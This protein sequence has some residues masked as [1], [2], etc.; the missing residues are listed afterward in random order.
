MSASLS[1]MGSNGR[2][3]GSQQRE[4]KCLWRLGNVVNIVPLV[5]VIC[6]DW[7]SGEIRRTG[8]QGSDCEEAIMPPGH[9]ESES[10]S[11]GEEVLIHFHAGKKQLKVQGWLLT[12]QLPQICV[13]F[14]RAEGWCRNIKDWQGLSSQAARKSAEWKPLGPD[15]GINSFAQIPS[16]WVNSVLV[17]SRG[18]SAG[19]AGVG[20]WLPGL[21]QAPEF[22]GRPQEADKPTDALTCWKEKGKRP[23]KCLQPS[24]LV[25]RGMSYV[26]TSLSAKVYYLILPAQLSNYNRCQALS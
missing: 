14:H 17:L 25:R 18:G 12:N 16:L 26:N 5:P 13:W 4:G 21:V 23:R 11:M 8:G 22:T 19:V 20:S 24:K 9:R 7:G 2:G 10:E 15:D 6:F 1:G 3:G